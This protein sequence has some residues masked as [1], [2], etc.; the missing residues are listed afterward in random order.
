MKNI[1]SV[2]VSAVLGA[3]LAVSSTAMAAQVNVNKASA[4]QISKDLM[5]V[6]LVKAQR[7]VDYCQKNSCA[8]P[9]DLINVKG[10]GQKTIDKNRDNLL[11]S[12][13]IN[14]SEAN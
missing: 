8:K 11:F 3:I 4:E 6:G 14:V 10:V 1:K 5:G 7:I 13:P 9:E 2:L 12:D